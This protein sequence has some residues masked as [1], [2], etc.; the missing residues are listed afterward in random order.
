MPKLK[1]KYRLYAKT[2]NV[3]TTIEGARDH[4]KNFYRITGAIIIDIETLTAI[5]EIKP[6]IMAGKKAKRKK[7]STGVDFV[8]SCGWSGKLFP[9]KD[10]FSQEESFCCPKCNK[11]SPARQ[12]KA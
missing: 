2:A 8:C 9:Q 1:N 11:E 6:Q 3:F 5:E 10:M 12:E 7:K 4:A